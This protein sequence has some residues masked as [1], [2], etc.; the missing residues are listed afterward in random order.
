MKDTK[1]II[2]IKNYSYKYTGDNTNTI[3]N[4]NLDIK[5]GEFI[6][7][8]GPT[9]CGKST[10]LK[11]IVG[12]MRS[13]Y[14]GE[15]SGSIQIENIDI[16]KL[17][18]DEISQKVGFVFQDPENQIFMFNVERD[19]AFG[20]ENLGIEKNDIKKRIDDVVELLK[21]K[22]II[23][24]APHE[25]SDGQKQRVALAGT[26]VMKP[27]VLILDEPTSMLDPKTAYD[28]LMLLNDLKKNRNITIIVVEHRLDLLIEIADRI[29]IMDKGKILGDDHPKKIIEQNKNIIKSLGLPLITQLSQKLNKEIKNIDIAFNAEE[30]IKKLEK[31]KN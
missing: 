29:V 11:S 20:L 6:L 7:L 26:L 19:I 22:K 16:K 24:K 9:G 2:S 15:E 1:D 28:L 31:N 14:D 25:L 27:I 3:K 4:I 21:I 12:I 17:E 8:C 30:L 10:L 13:L 18:M 5:E 23:N